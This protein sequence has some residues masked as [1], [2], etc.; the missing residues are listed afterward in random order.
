MI[1]VRVRGL[2]RNVQECL[3]ETKL[4]GGRYL[5]DSHLSCARPAWPLSQ[6]LRLQRI[7]GL[8]TRGQGLALGERVSKLLWQNHVTSSILLGP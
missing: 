2:E 5:S 3:W 6:I 7:W 8:G 1:K 4:M